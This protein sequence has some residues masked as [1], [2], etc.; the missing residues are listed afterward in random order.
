MLVENQEIIQYD[1]PGCP[2]FLFKYPKL[3]NHIYNSVE[4]SSTDEK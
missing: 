3:Y 4:F 1:K 2:F